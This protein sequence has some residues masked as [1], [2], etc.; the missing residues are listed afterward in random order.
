MLDFGLGMS[1]SSVLKR[2]PKEWHVRSWVPSIANFQP[3]SDYLGL[4]RLFQGFQTTWHFGLRIRQSAF[5]FLWTHNLIQTTHCRSL[6]QGFRGF[7]LYVTVL[8]LPSMYK[9]K[10]QIPWQMNAWLVNPLLKWHYWGFFRLPNHCVKRSLWPT[11]F[12]CIMDKSLRTGE[13]NVS[14]VKYESG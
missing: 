2:L 5:L 10:I 12:A 4:S 6:T 8:F 7:G 11:C 3:L 9:F 14:P 13:M 1:Y